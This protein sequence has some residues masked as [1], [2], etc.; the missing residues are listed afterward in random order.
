MGTSE[1]LVS[2]IN[3]YYVDLRFGRVLLRVGIS[4][5]GN[6]PYWKLGEL[7]P[8]MSKIMSSIFSMTCQE[9]KMN[10]P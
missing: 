10:L 7:D 5:K 3:A 6:L 2:W 8:S 9:I 4:G 1:D